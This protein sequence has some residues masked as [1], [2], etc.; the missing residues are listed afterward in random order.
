MACSLSQGRK[1]HKAL[2]F[3]YEGL[4]DFM[5]LSLRH[6]LMKNRANAHPALPDPAYDTVNNG[7]GEL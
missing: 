5:L 1:D 4:Y 6:F 2:L 3:S 7:K